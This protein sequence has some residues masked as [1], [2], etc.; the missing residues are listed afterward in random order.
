MEANGLLSAHAWL[1]W[2]RPWENQ[3]GKAAGWSSFRPKFCFNV[4][5]LNQTLSS[6]RQATLDAFHGAMHWVSLLLTV[7]PVAWSWRPNLDH[8]SSDQN[9]LSNKRFL[10]K[11]LATTP[12]WKNLWRELAASSSLPPPCLPHPSFLKG[13]RALLHQYSPCRTNLGP[14]FR[15]LALT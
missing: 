15:L 2:A 1:P 11:S 4:R 10:N 7:L 6:R 9:E 13:M 5:K 3:G 14:E 8:L 12:V